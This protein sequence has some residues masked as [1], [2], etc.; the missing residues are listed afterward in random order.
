[1]K[2]IVLA[3]LMALSFA[4]SSGLFA[5]ANAAGV[6]QRLQRRTRPRSATAADG[7]KPGCAEGPAREGRPFACI[8]VAVRGFRVRVRA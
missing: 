6:E 7:A 2:K 8:R 3:G 5:A 4:V 1:M